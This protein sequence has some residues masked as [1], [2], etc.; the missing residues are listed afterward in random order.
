VLDRAT[1]AA[2]RQADRHVDGAAGLGARHVEHRLVR[3]LG[4]AAAVAVF[5]VEEAVVVLVGD[6]RGRAAGLDAAGR[7]LDTA[8]GFL[9]AAV[10]VVVTVVMPQ[11]GEG[12]GRREAREQGDGGDEGDTE[13]KHGEISGEKR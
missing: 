4:A 3:R 11:A 9:H 13:A 7:L 1:V 5:L 12:G 8:R 10:G 2:G 6:A